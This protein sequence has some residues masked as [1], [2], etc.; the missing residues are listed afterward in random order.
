MGLLTVPDILR[1]DA[2][3]L[4]AVFEVCK[5]RQ[6]TLDT[7]GCNIQQMNNRLS[8]WKG[9]TADA[10]TAAA[11][12]ART[13]IEA[14]GSESA[15][16][17]RALSTAETGVRQVKK[18]LVELL[19]EAEGKQIEVDDS[20]ACA[21]KKGHELSPQS[22]GVLLGFQQRVTNVMIQA[23]TVD[24]E[25][26]FAI[27]LAVMDKPV[28]QAAATVSD[29][30]DSAGTTEAAAKAI[31]L[32]QSVGDGR[33]YVYGGTG[34]GYDCS[35]A[36]SAVFAAATGKP[37]ST[38]YFTTESDFEALGF[39]KGYMPGAYNV[40]IHRGGG[41]MNSHMAATLPNGVNFESG[42]SHNSTLYGGSAAGATDSQFELHYYLPATATRSTSVSTSTSSTNQTSD[43]AQYA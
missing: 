13:D 35:G 15:V 40:G 37:Q 24:D 3:S 43:T 4:A 38:R 9:E 32:A 42:G 17:A 39:K 21:F 31:A 36:Q 8:D 5:K 26:A 16:V 7:F 34:P 25:I 14:D 23:M 1:W 12:K 29:A 22:M 19:D 2:P 33:A 20:G 11:G 41:G 28:A 18:R 6:G 30:A 10:L 27:R